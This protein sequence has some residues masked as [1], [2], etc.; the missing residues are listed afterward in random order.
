MAP[1]W[2]ERV[3][4]LL[5]TLEGRDRIQVI[6]QVA[7]LAFEVPEHR[8]DA[9]LDGNSTW[10]AQRDETMRLYGEYIVENESREAARLLALPDA[11]GSSFL[12]IAGEKARVGYHRVADMFEHVDF[13]ACRR[14]T[15]VGC[16]PLPVTAL[17]VMERAG[18]PECV[19]L[20]VSAERLRAVQALRDKFGW[21]A[22]RPQLCDGK[23]FDYA[24]AGVVYVANMVRSK[25]ET[26][27]RILATTDV[28]VQLVVREPYSLGR[29][30]SEKIEGLLG[31][32]VEVLGRGPVSGHLSRDLYLRK[33]AVPG[34]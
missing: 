6:E 10:A 11:A 3:A 21:S 23:S 12:E 17:H 8:G 14:F 26:V 5:A 22:L 30:W 19:L 34:A 31:P 1:S 32:E 29:L 13:G 24:G 9:W 20:D 16:G 25:L 15:M 18:V 4:R 2:D 7:Q 28:D 33:R 27:S